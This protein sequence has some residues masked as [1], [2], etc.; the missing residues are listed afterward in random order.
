MV[1]LVSLFVNFFSLPHEYD[2]LTFAFANFVQEWKSR[3]DVE[4]EEEAPTGESQC[5]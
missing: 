2:N 1:V 3:L 4:R 5:R